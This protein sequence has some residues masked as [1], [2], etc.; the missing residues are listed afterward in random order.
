MGSQP[1]LHRILLR[2]AWVLGR[3]AEIGQGVDCIV[4]ELYIFMLNISSLAS[5]RV[6][7]L[8]SRVQWPYTGQAYA[9]RII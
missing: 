9:K 8:Y 2:Y 1:N 3:D 6:A 4:V 5:S 7:L